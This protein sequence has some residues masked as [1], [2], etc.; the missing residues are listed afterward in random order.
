M[1]AVP[2]PTALALPVIRP[3]IRNSVKYPQAPPENPP[4]IEDVAAGIY[5]FQEIYASR[6]ESPSTALQWQIGIV[7]GAFSREK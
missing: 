2:P 7:D 4:S 6:S 5:L 1:A 3:A